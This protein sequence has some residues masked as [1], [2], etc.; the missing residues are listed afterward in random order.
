[1][2]DHRLIM[3]L[4]C[5]QAEATRCEE[6]LRTL[7]SRLAEATMV[8][9]DG[10]L[11]R[12]R[13]AV[14]NDFLGEC[15]TLH[16]VASEALAGVD[17]SISAADVAFERLLKTAKAPAPAKDTVEL[18]PADMRLVLEIIAARNPDHFDRE[19]DERA[20]ARVV[21]I[22]AAALEEAP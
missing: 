20:C 9:F 13:I 10:S 15:I 3:E 5:A 2:V 7:R 12:G 17:S 14:A 19:C 22:L 4:A 21:S 18:T 6:Y 11:G 1:M 8:L 16:E